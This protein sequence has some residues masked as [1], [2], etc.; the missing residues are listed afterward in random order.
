MSQITKLILRVIMERLKSQ[1]KE[2]VSEEQYGFVEGKETR[3][4]LFIY[5]NTIGK[6]E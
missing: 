4:V 5:E 6:Y 2:E 1:I 3:N